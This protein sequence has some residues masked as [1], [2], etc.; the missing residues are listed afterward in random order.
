MT[1][2]NPSLTTD[3]NTYYNYPPMETQHIDPMYEALVLENTIMGIESS[4][5]PVLEPQMEPQLNVEANQGQMND[6]EYDDHM[7]V[8]HNIVFEESSASEEDDDQDEHA[9]DGVVTSS[10]LW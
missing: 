7:L 5:E 4:Y 9:Q 8:D 2:V 6:P 3:R 10:T 1:Q